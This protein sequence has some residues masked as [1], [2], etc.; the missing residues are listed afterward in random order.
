MKNTYNTNCYY[1]KEILLH[2]NAFLTF[3]KFG[4]EYRCCHTPAHLRVKMPEQD[5]NR[6]RHAPEDL[7]FDW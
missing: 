4:N 3:Y 6:P 7:H 2:Y 5:L 1:Q